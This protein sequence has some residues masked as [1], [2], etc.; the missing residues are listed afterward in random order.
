M[1]AALGPRRTCMLVAVVVAVT[2]AGCGGGGNGHGP[3]RVGVMLPL[4]GPDAVGF[5]A[6]LEWARD[7]VNAAGGIDG[8]PL[9]LVWADIG[10]QPAAQVAQRFAKDSSIAAAI[11]PD[12]SQDALG[13][14]DTFVKAHKPIVTPSATSADLFRA[15]S[16][17][18]PHYFWRP[19]ES[20]IAQARELLALAAGG[21]ARSVALVTGQHAYGTTFFDWFGFLAVEANVQVTATIRYDQTTQPCDDAMGQALASGADAL[22]A[23]PNGA[24][25]AACMVSAWRAHG[26]VSH[27]RLLFSDSAQDPSLLTSLGPAVEGVEGTGLAPD[28]A[29]GFAAGYQAHFGAPPPPYAANTYDSLLLIAYG[30]ARTH[31]KGGAALATGIGAVTAGTGPPV[32]WDAAGVRGALAAIHAG[33]LPTVSG[34]V[35]PWK[36]DRLAGTELV[37][38]TYEHW[39]V[40]GGRFTVVAY[41]P[42]ANAPTA[43]AGVSEAQDAPA[44]ANQAE[45]V[46]GAYVP[47]PRTG[48][49]ALLVAASDGWDNY[50]HQAD[51]LA[52]YQRLRANGVPANR[53]VVV[54]ANDIADNRRNAPRGTVRYVVGGPNL[55]GG[56]RADYSP[57]RLSAGQLMDVLAGRAGP[58]TPKVIDSGAGDDVY[59]YMAGHGNDNGI[60]LGLGQDVPSPNNPY[61]ILSP[62]VLGGTVAAMAA[63][64]RYRRILVALEACQSGTFGA[65]LKAPGALL[66][67]AAGPTEDSLSANYDPALDN[68]LA[69]QFSY[70]LWLAEA[71]PTLSL[72]RLY[73]RVY[74]GVDGS[75]VR[76]Y[77]A[78]FGDPA[79]V[80][81]G[82]FLTP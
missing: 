78:D 59:V 35:G 37:E 54:M 53:I 75:H 25:Q 19:V 82:E 4:T 32:S 81:V 57:T 60:Y 61:S 49:W 39:R 43:R 69:D 7:A 12:N 50:R 46:S 63:Q 76:A 28:P 79:A 24:Q 80:S 68:W 66:L 58:A 72:D 17:T 36:F 1:V 11:G 18:E 22:V 29:S 56:V 3:L 70:Q 77:G 33:Q 40:T 27:P 6:P 47:G 9:E 51:V 44:P 34:A 41:L 16:A 45:A 48:T 2:L 74:L 13:A 71:P 65:S 67:T 31:G 14:A 15:F 26:S 21:G 30:L 5:Q 42:T 20:D 64:H 38:S 8:R 55:Y 73:R 10:R 23:V 52:Q 62:D